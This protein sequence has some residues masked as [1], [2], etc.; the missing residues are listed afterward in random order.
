MKRFLPNAMC[1]GEILKEGNYKNIFIS[2]PNLSFSG[3]GNF[4]KLT[5]MMNYMVKRNLMNLILNITVNLGVTV[6]M[7]VF[8]LNFQKKKLM[9]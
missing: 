7:I 6:Q 2:S 1:L 3:T 4:L 9:I 8:F 5:A